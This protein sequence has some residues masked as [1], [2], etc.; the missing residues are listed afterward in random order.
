MGLV[1]VLEKDGDG[2]KTKWEGSMLDGPVSD[3]AWTREEPYCICAVGGGKKR[4]AA[5][6]VNNGSS[7]GQITG[8]TGDV[9]S[10]DI[11]TSMKMAL[12]GADSSL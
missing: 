4:A 11:G 2:F 6:N 7:C 1:R 12:T 9:Y 8:A 10:V 5:V 3:I